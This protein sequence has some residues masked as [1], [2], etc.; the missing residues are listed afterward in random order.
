[1]ESLAFQKNSS[2]V[3][4]L[5]SIVQDKNLV[6]QHGIVRAGAIR[7]LGLCR[8]LE[9][10]DYLVSLTEEP[11]LT[12]ERARPWIFTSLAQCASWISPI[13]KKKASEILVAHLSDE[14]EAVRWRCILGLV[15]LGDKSSIPNIL[16]SE[17]LWDSRDFHDVLRQV[18]ELKLVEEVGIKECLK[19]LELMEKRLKTLEFSQ[20]FNKT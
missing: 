13:H 9:A 6:G 12:H 20:F 4:L 14:I 5:L 7:A 11:G 2:D 19:Q 16:A 1:M 8:T 10:F 15:H 17:S 3:S 18:R